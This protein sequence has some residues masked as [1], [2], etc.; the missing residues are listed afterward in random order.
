[1]FEFD[2]HVHTNLSPCAAKD[3]E[4]AKIISVQEKRGIKAMG[5]ADHAFSYSNDSKL[6]AK[7]RKDIKGASTSSSIFL[8]VEA[9]MLSY[10]RASISLDFASEFDYVLIAPNHYHLRG[11]E[12]PN[13]NNPRDTA[14]H[15]IFMF[16]AAVNCPVADVV[17]H[18]FVFSYKV[19]KM[20]KE[21]MAEY[22]KEIMAYVDSKKLAQI[23]D[24]AAERGIAVEL[25]PKFQLLGQTHLTDF[26][27]LC[28]D[29][30]LK[31]AMGSDAHAVDELH[32][33]SLLEPTL[34]ELDLKNENLWHPR[35]WR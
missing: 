28:I 21:A 16:E 10:R 13:F 27:R 34:K 7:L 24:V 31:L 8:G 3:M 35:E 5:F 22:S 19:F 6:P 29:R 9:E 20:E 18:P 25:N 30:R 33:L 1:M 26:Y 11:V 17:A 2:Y 15:E 23:L 12:C 4:I 14:A 32:N